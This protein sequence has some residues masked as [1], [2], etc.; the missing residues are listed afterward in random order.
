VKIVK[1]PPHA[2]RANAVCE[3]WVGTAR[4][5]CTDRI[6]ITGRRHLSAVL[7]EFAGHYNGHRPH[8]SPGQ[9]LPIPRPAPDAPPAEGHV[10]R[11]TILGGLVSEYPAAA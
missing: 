2:S 8:Q 9:R 11:R 4:R 7:R 3:R 1:T 6:L 5:G 10:R